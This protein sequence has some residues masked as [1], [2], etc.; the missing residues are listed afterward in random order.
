MCLYSASDTWPKMDYAISVGADGDI[1]H[2]V[3]VDGDNPLAWL[4]MR[5]VA[6]R[7]SAKCNI[8]TCCGRAKASCGITYDF[9]DWWGWSTEWDPFAFTWHVIY[10]KPERFVL[11]CD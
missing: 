8:Q 2:D 7:A 5:G 1:Q 10:Q 11:R 9:Y 6:M 4:T 3:H